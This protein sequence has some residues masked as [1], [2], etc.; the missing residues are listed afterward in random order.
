MATAMLLP[1][2]LGGSAMYALS[3]RGPPRTTPRSVLCVARRSAALKHSSPFKR[4]SSMAQKL[5]RHQDCAEQSPLRLPGAMWGLR[6]PVLGS[7]NS[8]VHC[9]GLNPLLCM[10][11]ME[12]ECLQDEWRYTGTLPGNMETWPCGRAWRTLQVVGLPAVEGA[13]RAAHDVHAAVPHRCWR[14]DLPRAHHLP[15]A[16]DAGCWQ[17][18]SVSQP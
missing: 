6:I 3:M 11:H 12:T 15:R 9:I 4:L 2:V 14:G 5:T 8:V 17:A 16:A 7:S 10:P 18:W 13:V 1:P